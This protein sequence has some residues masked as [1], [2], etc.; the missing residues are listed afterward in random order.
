MSSEVAGSILNV[1]PTKRAKGN[2]LCSRTCKTKTTMKEIRSLQSHSNTE[3]IGG[4]IG[5]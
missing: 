3:K 4:I 5:Y 1:F 2:I